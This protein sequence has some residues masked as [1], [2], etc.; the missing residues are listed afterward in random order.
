[1]YGWLIVFLGRLMGGER[2]Q[3]ATQLDY[4]FQFGFFALFP[5]LVAI[6]AFA[7]VGKRIMDHGSTLAIWTYSVSM[8]LMGYVAL[9][10]WGKWIPAPISLVAGICIWIAAFWVAWHRF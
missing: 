5:L 7:P 10:L 1:M 4:R 3:K 6:F 9:V 2:L 8:G